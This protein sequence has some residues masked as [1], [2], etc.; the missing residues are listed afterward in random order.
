RKGRCSCPATPTRGGSCCRASSAERSRTRARR[1]RGKRPRTPTSR[2]RR[3]TPR[4]R[5]R[6]T[7]KARDRERRCR[8]KTTAIRTMSNRLVLIDGS[9]YLYRAYH[10]LPKLSSSK[11]DPTG[12]LFGV[13]NMIN[14]LFREEP[15]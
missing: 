7:P 13:L 11:G 10:A 6:T 15:S 5:R 2:H 14:K 9:S 1:R 8:R 12:A 4:H 3:R